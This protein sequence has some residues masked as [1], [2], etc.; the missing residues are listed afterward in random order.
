MDFYSGN[1]VSF[2]MR[3][4]A[5]HVHMEAAGLSYR[6][7]LGTRNGKSHTVKSGNLRPL[8]P[9]TDAEVPLREIESDETWTICD[10]DS[11]EIVDDIHSKYRKPDWWPLGAVLGIVLFPAFSFPSLIAGGLLA[12]LLLFLDRRRKTTVIVY[13]I[14]P[15]TEQKIR[16][17][18]DTFNELIRAEKK[19]HVSASGEVREQQRKYHAGAG[20][21]V[22]RSP[23]DIGFSVPRYVRTNVKVPCVPV[24]KQKLYFFPDRVLLVERRKVGAVSYGNLSL[25]C[26]NIRFI[27]EE[28]VPRDTRVVGHTWR[29]VNKNGGPD[30]RFKD[31][32]QLPICLYSELRFRSGTGLH[33]MIQVSRPDAGIR[34]M[35]HLNDADFSYVRARA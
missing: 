20:T 30:K 12:L 29:Y 16:S 21:V 2:G 32:R 14:D 22:K 24:G 34:L 7:T 19:W 27:E 9:R 3:P 25:D 15:S 23:I 26:A 10:A 1:A 35:G 17:F 13:H 18:Y 11:R 5:H 8:G 33:E 31:N 4:G 28:A 6:K